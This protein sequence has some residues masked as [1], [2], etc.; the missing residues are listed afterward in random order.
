MVR[1]PSSRPP[2]Q[3]GEMPP[4]GTKLP[5]SVPTTLINP[6]KLSSYPHKIIVRRKQQQQHPHHTR[7]TLGETGKGCGGTRM[8]QGGVW[9]YESPKTTWIK[10]R[11]GTADHFPRAS[12]ASVSLCIFSEC[13]RYCCFHGI[14]SRPTYL[15]TEGKSSSKKW[16]SIFLF[17]CI[18]FKFV[19]H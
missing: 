15:D 7:Y 19:F 5:I 8:K 4:M 3:C 18:N 16:L 1:H 17:L 6:N 11:N 9:T 2:P 10:P 14:I 12:S 13:R